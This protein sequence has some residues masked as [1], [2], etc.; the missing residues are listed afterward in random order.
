MKTKQVDI[1][2]ISGLSSYEL[3]VLTG[4]F[5]GTLEEYV[6]REQLMYDKTVAYTDKAKAEM[7]EMLASA[8][9]AFPAQSVAEL[10][11]ARASYKTLGLRLGA[12]DEQISVILE[13]L[14]QLDPTS[15]NIDAVRVIGSKRTVELRNNGVAI[16]WRVLGEED[17]ND[18]ISLNDITPEFKV[19]KVEIADKADEADV[20]ITGTRKNPV[21]NFKFPKGKDGLD[22]GSIFNARVN[23]KGELIVNVKNG[24]D[25]VIITDEE[26]NKILVPVFSIG[27]VESVEWD[28]KPYVTIT[29]TPTNPILN[30]G[31]PKPKPVTVKRVYPGEDGF[32]KIDLE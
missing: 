25:D 2:K 29:G 10:I 21:L 1:G 31:L 27:E 15:L 19:G 17:W 30:F 7:E 4:Q 22:G 20:K 26:G 6:R 32:I 23:D 13:R 9:E 28:E 16:Q 5:E 18:L 11:N 24:D 14:N 8:T 3:A 12:T